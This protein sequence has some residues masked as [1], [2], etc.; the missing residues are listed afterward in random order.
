MTSIQAGYSAQAANLNVTSSAAESIQNRIGDWLTQTGAGMAIDSINSTGFDQSWKDEAIK[1]LLSQCPPPAITPP[2]CSGPDVPPPSCGPVESAPGCPANPTLPVEGTPSQEG[3]ALR[4]LDQ[5]KD[6][7]DQIFKQVMDYVSKGGSEESQ[8]AREGRANAA[9]NRDSSVEGTEGTITADMDWFT[10]L[11]H[12]MGKTLQTQGEN[13][14][15]LSEQ[16]SKMVETEKAAAAAEGNTILQ[17]GGAISPTI[18]GQTD[19]A[20]AAATGSVNSQNAAGQVH[21]P[22]AAAKSA[23]SIELQTKLSSETMKMQFL[24]TG[25]QGALKAVSDSL[26]TMGRS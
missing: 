12:A 2:G 5:V 18:P 15:T 13:I 17:R 4:L 7:M 24:S 9:V 21:N 23:G 16:L 3:E 8:S 22:D 20:G 1:A 11:A 10:A 14:K 26:N 25:L 19:A 6:L